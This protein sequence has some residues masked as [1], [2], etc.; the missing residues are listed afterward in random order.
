MNMVT[1]LLS[2]VANYDWELQQYDVKNAL[3]YGDLEEKIYM[4]IPPDF[5]GELRGKRVCKLKKALYELKQS[6]RVWF[7]RFSKAMTIMGYNQSQGD[8][9]LFI[10]HSK[11]GG[12]T[13]LLVYVDDIIVIRN[14]LEEREALRC[15]WQMNLRSKT[16]ASLN[17]FLE[18]K[19][20]TPREQYLSP[21]TNTCWIC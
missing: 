1:I 5:G 7:G 21:N 6:P 20:L 18:L 15:Q 13:T 16:L 3:L 2:V 11:L 9:T 8:H 17:T 4:E 14:D 19:W 12:V 10:N